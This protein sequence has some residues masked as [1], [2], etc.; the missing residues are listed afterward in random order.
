MARRDPQPGETLEAIAWVG[1]LIILA[2]LVAHLLAV[3]G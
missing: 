2:A 3:R 1:V